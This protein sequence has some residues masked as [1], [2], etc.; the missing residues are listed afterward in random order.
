MATA[1]QRNA[2]Q[3]NAF[4][5][6]AVG[7]APQWSPGKRHKP[8]V[9]EELLRQQR[10]SGPFTRAKFE[11]LLARA[12]AKAKTAPTKVRKAIKKAIAEAEIAPV[13]VYDPAP[14]MAALE[15]AIASRKA[16]EIIAAAQHAEAI[17][18]A[19]LE[20]L[21]RDEEEAIALLF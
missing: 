10:E 18:R 21:E 3:N 16:L 19:Y 9:F 7:W 20:E 15:V 13:Q 11:E 8:E 14:L 2:F 5:I 6:A 4:Q 1:F 12:A 17:A